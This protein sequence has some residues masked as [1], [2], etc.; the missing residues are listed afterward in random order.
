MKLDYGAMI[1]PSPICLNVGTIRKPKLGEISDSRKMGFQQFKFLEGFLTLTPKEY[2]SVYHAESKGGYWEGLSEDERDSVSMF[3]AISKDEALQEIYLTLFRFFFE[4]PVDYYSGFFI[5]LKPGTVIHEDMTEDDIVCVLNEELFRQVLNV[6]K[7][8][9]GMKADDD[10]FVNI[11]ANMF[12]NAKAKALYE[13][14]RKNTVNK[15]EN[16]DNYRDYTLPNIISK[17]C[18][19]HPSINYTNV[20]DLTIYELLDNFDAMRAN[21]I[22]DIDQTRVSVWGDEKNTFRLDS[23]YKNEYDKKND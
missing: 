9:C 22:Y 3:Q 15:S 7:Q 23:W 4:E 11:P 5:I 8:I 1:S 18:A 21:A 14:M 17:V 2:Y 13:R 19:R 12:K 6:L 16:P 10:E 20:W